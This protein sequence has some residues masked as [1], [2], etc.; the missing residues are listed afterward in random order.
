MTETTI[1]G[2]R[3]LSSHWPPGPEYTSM[4]PSSPGVTLATLDAHAEAPPPAYRE[5]RKHDQE[6]VLAAE[7]LA[8]LTKR[9]PPPPGAGE[10]EDGSGASQGHSAIASPLSSLLIQ[11]DEDYKIQ[12]PLVSRVNQVSRHPIVT[13]AVRYYN[14]SKRNYAL[15]NYAAEFVE[16]AAIPVVSR[17][18]ADLNSRHQVKQAAAA[19]TDD[20]EVSPHRKLR[21]LSSSSTVATAKSVKS[22]SASTA[23]TRK[24]LQFCLHVLKLTNDQITTKV[25]ELQAKIQEREQ[26]REKEQA[27]KIERA[28][29]ASE[30][31]HAS[32][33]QTGPPGAG[34][35]APEA[36]QTKT[37]IVST[38]KKIIHVISNFRPS[39]LSTSNGL[40]P[41]SSQSSENCDFKTTIRDIILQ[42]PT[43]VQQ[44]TAAKTGTG[45]QANDRIFLLAKESLD[46]ITRLT[47]VFSVQ[48]EK[49]DNWVAGEQEEDE[50]TLTEYDSDKKEDSK[51]S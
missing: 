49:A 34:L 38:V 15:F 27:Q 2:K 6:L 7:A 33:D 30:A 47:T 3:K 1:H 28:R 29:R 20:N 50:L 37:E 4:P 24:R 26:E 39:S 35:I 42:L 25:S 46:M 10:S 22:N 43:T 19:I 44:T 14:H 8:L 18:E 51:Y 11:G 17:I 48:L 32:Q 23:D 9:T 12:H 40:T 13:N 5:K 41:T 36:Q 21:R 45:Q 31:S 16:K